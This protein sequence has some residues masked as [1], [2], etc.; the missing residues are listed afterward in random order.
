MKNHT[1]PERTKRT[2]SVGGDKERMLTMI[3]TGRTW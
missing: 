3:T 1:C 2:Y